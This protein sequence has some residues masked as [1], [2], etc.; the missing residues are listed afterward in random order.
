MLCS[1]TSSSYC[2]TCDDCGGTIFE[3]DSVQDDDTCLCQECFDDQYYLRT[4]AQYYGKYEKGKREVP[5]GFIIVLLIIFSGD[6]TPRSDKI[7]KNED[8][9]SSVFCIFHPGV[10]K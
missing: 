8:N 7:D 1:I 6:C 3:D 5:F 2:A 4:T 10:Q 9:I